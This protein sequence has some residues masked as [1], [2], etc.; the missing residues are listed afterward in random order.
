MSRFRPVTA[1]CAVAAAALALTILATGCGASGDVA[2]T[3]AG[4][5]YSADD[6]DDYLATTDPDNEARAARA[7]AAAWLSDWVFF[8]AV[9][10]ELAERGVTV[11]NE[12]TAQ[13]V[14]ELTEADPSFVPGAAGGDVAIRQ[15]AVVV[16]ALEWVEREVPAAPDGEPLRHLC[17]RHILVASESEA[18]DVLSRLDGGEEFGLLALDLSLDP[19]SGSLGGDLGCVVEGSFVA[20]FEDAAYAAEP[21]DVVTAESQ[22]GFHVIEV[23][24]SG[25]ATAADHP[26][27]DAET[28]ASMAEDA[29]LAALERSQAGVQA[30]RNELLVELQQAVFDQYATQVSI[31]DRYGRWDPDRFQVVLEPA[32]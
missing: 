22:F 30:E 14:A 32:G 20:P 28:L 10:L 2:A 25:P 6:L 26:Q 31:H 29:E 13:A 27:L 12:H 15:R 8:T 7:D 4:A 5:E 18:A 17:S 24:S 11:T 1:V 9:E 16:A 3:V 19:G 23:I 21:G